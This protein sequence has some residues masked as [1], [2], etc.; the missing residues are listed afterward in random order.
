MAEVVASTSRTLG[1]AGG[2]TTGAGLGLAERYG[3]EGAHIDA[4]N[5]A[6]LEEYQ[7]AGRMQEAEDS[8]SRRQEH[9]RRPDAEGEADEN[10]DGDTGIPS[11]ATK[12]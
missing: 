11:W 10:D 8:A 9:L 2:D 6:V 12:D 4:V 1:V 5:P 3:Y 7:A